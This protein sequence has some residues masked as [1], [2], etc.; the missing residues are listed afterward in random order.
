VTDMQQMFDGA[1][2]FNQDIGNWNV[3]NVTEMSGMF[4]GASAFDQDIGSW[5]VSNVFSMFFM[6]NNAGLSTANYDN[7]LIGWSGLPALQSGLTF[8]AGSSKYCLG[9]A[10]R[11]NLI[12]N[13]NWTITDGG[14]DLACNNFLLSCPS[15]IV[16]TNEAGVCGATVNYTIISGA[17]CADETLTQIAGLPSGSVFP[18]GITTNTFQVTDSNGNTTTCSFTVT[19]TD[20]MSPVPDVATLPDATGECSITLSAPTATDNCAGSITGTTTDPLTY[21]TQGTYT[22]TW[23]FDDGNGNTA[24]QQQTVIVNDVSAPVPDAASLPDATGECEASV[25]VPTATDNCT[26]SVTATTTDPTSYTEQ[27]TYMVTWIFD[28]GNGNTTQQQQTVVVEDM[29]EPTA[30]C[31]DVTVQLDGGGNV[32]ITGADIDGGSTDNCGIT[33]LESEFASF[34]CGSTGVQNVQL[35]VTDVAGNQSFCTAAVTVVDNLPPVAV[36]QNLTL[37]LDENGQA[38]FQ[39]SDLDNGSSDNCGISGYAIVNG[40]ASFGNCGA[41]GGNSAVLTVFD[42]SGNSSTCLAYVTVIDNLPPIAQCKDITLNLDASGNASIQP[43]G[44]N[45]DNGSTDN[46][47]LNVPFPFALSQY[48]FDCND[49]GA[50]TVTQTVTDINGNTSTCTGTVTVVDNI[51]PV[52]LCQDLT[53]ELDASGAGSITPGDVNN[54]SNDACG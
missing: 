6:F 36:C 48:F 54:G 1:T 46:C 37:V 14:K 10:G 28:D 16:T 27:G 39:P 49:V 13:H 40:P 8:H 33:S 32:T 25:S 30:T 42:N 20:D 41:V 5:D 7:L 19:V 15:D 2:A 34:T 50:N 22:V 38:P 12:N 9:A 4:A 23:T 11:C 53:V 26:G 47:G 45:I 43:P 35:T 52:A 3:G 31:Q 44:G 21:S 51:L 29:T 17:G 18:V 24:Q